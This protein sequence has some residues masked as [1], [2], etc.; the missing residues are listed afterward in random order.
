MFNTFKGAAIAWA[1]LTVISAYAAPDEAAIVVTAT[2]QQQRANELLSDITVITSDEIEQAGPATLPELLSRQPGMSMSS[3]GG[4]G[5]SASLSM[6]GAEARHTLLLIDGLR[7]NSATTGQSALENIPL[8][9]IERIEILRGP[10]GVLYGSDALGGVIQVFT[11][12]GEGDFKPDAFAGFGRYG[13]SDLGAGF[14]GGSGTW[15]YSLR[16]AH[17]ETD[18]FSAIGNKAKQPTS[19]NPDRDGFKQDSVSASIGLRFRE[20]D[21][22]GIRLLQSTGRN[23]YD[24]GPSLYDAHLDKSNASYDVH[25]HNRLNANWTSRLLLGHGSDEQQNHTSTTATSLFRT[26]QEQLSWQNDVRL[27]VGMAL[28]ALEKLSQRID[29]TTRYTVTQRDISSLLLGWNARMAAHRLQF[30]VRHDDNSQFGGKATGV[31]A[32]G[33]QL[34]PEWRAHVSAGTAFNA[35]TFNQLYFP[36]SGFGGGNPNL[37]PER[38]RNREASLIWEKG[39]HRLALTHFDNHI[40]DMIAGW[41]PVNIGQARLRGNTLSYA[42]T[43]AEWQFDASA[44]GLLARDEVTGKVLPRRVEDRINARLTRSFG[45]HDV[46]IEIQG[47]GPSYDDTN[48]TR[49]MGGY[50]LLNV[51]AR[52]RPRANWSIEARASNLGN[53]PYETTWGYANPGASLFVSLRY[54]PK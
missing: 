16:A 31:V 21:E 50:G 2:R 18:G 27:P 52:Y 13:T 32:Y 38:A 36:N 46:G 8:S 11:R 44:D 35:P 49:R 34:S 42:Y 7:I 10:A 17:Y 20:K 14:S 48:N 9:Q 5:A 39:F 23:Q 24:N 30:D 54:S 4:P 12:R 19:Y 25:M 47:N 1:L 33:Y 37:K 43:G 45:G 15:N 6:R 28:I 41:P 53:R 29:S 26:N 22:I 51:F 40:A 3:N